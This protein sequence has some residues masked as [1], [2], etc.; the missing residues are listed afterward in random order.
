MTTMHVEGF[1]WRWVVIVVDRERPKPLL[2]M[3]M[4]LQKRNPLPNPKRR[5][6]LRHLRST[7]RARVGSAQPSL[8]LQYE[9]AVLLGTTTAVS[10][11][12]VWY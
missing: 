4:V 2:R 7:N 12:Y 8:L 11:Y 3:Q 1:D 9:I 10:Y 6:N 5:T